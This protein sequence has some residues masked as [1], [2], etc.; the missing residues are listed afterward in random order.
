MV[1][2]LTLTIRCDGASRGNPGPAGIGIIIEDHSSRPLQK[3]IKS[4]GWATN[5][6]AEYQALLLALRMVHRWRA[7]HIRILL[8]SELIVKQLQGHYR[9][10]A[11][12]LVKLHQQAMDLLKLF[13]TVAIEWV[14]REHNRDPDALAKQAIDAVNRSSEH[15]LY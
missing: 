15:R 6:E 13:D 8:D 14:P 3:V 12:S 11:P 10:R 5:N 7:Q 9:V 2:P 4:I 1:Q